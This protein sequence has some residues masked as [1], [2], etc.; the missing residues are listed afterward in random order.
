[1]LDRETRPGE[2]DI[3]TLDLGKRTVSRLTFGGG[4]SPV[5][6]ADGRSV[7]F[8]SQR[9][10]R[11]EL[12]EKPAD[13]TSVERLLLSSNSDKSAIA[14]SP[15]GQWIAFAARGQIER[16]IWIQP[17]GGD[18]RP[19]SLV[20]TPFEANNP[21]FS[22]DGRWLAYTSDQTGRREVY[23]RSFPAGSAQLQVS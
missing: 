4:S 7:I 1:A 8:T 15:D 21:H 3:W 19:F 11:S 23:V 13:G 10:G 18:R 2:R 6:S 22:H 20:E 17:L 9:N 12:Y 16:G 14:V 5:W